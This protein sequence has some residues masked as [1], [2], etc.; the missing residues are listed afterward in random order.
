LVAPVKLGARAYVG[1]ASCITKDVPADSLALGRGIQV[2][3]EGW[4]RKKRERK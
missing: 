1:A 4:A 3:K 2:I